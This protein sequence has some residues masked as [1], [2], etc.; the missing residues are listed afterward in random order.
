MNARLCVMQAFLFSALSPV[1][2]SVRPG[3]GLGR[4]WHSEEGGGR[5][6]VCIILLTEHTFYFCTGIRFQLILPK[7]LCFQV[8][9]GEASY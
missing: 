6:V 1:G 5:E 7:M 8:I 4:M 9:H 3:L 2:L